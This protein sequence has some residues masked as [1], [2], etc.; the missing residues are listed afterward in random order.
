MKRLFLA[1]ISFSGMRQ[2]FVFG[3][4][5]RYDTTRKPKLHKDEQADVHLQKGFLRIHEKKAS[6]SKRYVKGTLI[7]HEINISKTLIML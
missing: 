4:L 6:T 3:N 5:G 1:V 2:N 7:V